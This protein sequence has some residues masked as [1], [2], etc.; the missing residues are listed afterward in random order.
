M[1]SLPIFYLGQ[2]GYLRGVDI[3]NQLARLRR[4]A[5][6]GDCVLLLEHPATITL[7]RAAKREHLI[8]DA[9]QLAREGIEVIDT[10]RGGDITYHGPGQLIGYPIVDLNGCGRDLHL[11]LRKL[12]GCL[13]ESIRSLGLAARR[14]PP[15]TGVWI[16][17]RKIAA[18]GIKVSHWI[19]THGF[20]LNV[21]PKMDHFDM[22]VP[23]G[24]RDYGVTS[25][26][27]ELDRNVALYEVTIPIAAALRSEFDGGSDCRSIEASIAE[28]LR[29]LPRAHLI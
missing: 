29:L 26:S 24:I 18:I 5:A 11:Y 16:G 12:E 14:F 21:S 9:D 10:D 13:I 17:D 20:A 6:T 23:C 2:V 19:T 27:A 3:Q 8:A 4:E 22:I 28:V 7:G 25:L 1:N 15:H